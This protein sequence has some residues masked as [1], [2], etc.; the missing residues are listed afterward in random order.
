MCMSKWIKDV[1]PGKVLCGCV[2][3]LLF[4]T[5]LM[6]AGPDPE[7][8]VLYLPFEDAT[9]PIDGS[10]DPT[11]VVIHGSLNSADG[12]LGTKGLEFD[13]NNANRVEVA[14]A[15]KLDGMSALTIEAWV[16]TRGVA[17]YEGMSLASKRIAFGDGDVY[18]LFIY[19][20]QLVNGRVNA[21]NTNVGLSTTVIQDD[22]W[23]HIALVFDGQGNAGEK[24]KLYINGVLE[25]S[26]DHPDSG[27]N[28]GDAPIWIGELD[29]ARGFAWDGVL[30]EIG[31]WNIALSE[32]D[33]N[34]LMV[35][36]KAKMLRGE[37]AGTPIPSDGAD[38]VPITT[39]LAW[40]PGEY[41]VTH[42]VYFGTVF[43]D[44]N[45]GA[46]TL[47]SQGQTGTSYDPD[48]VLE[49]G[50]TY[51]WRVDEV[52]GAPDNTTFKGD[53]WSFTAEPMGYPIERI[54]A[55]S[56]GMSQAGAL[57]DNT[58][59][60]SGL[61][62]DDQHSVDSPDMW[63][64]TRTG[65]EPLYIAFEF[66]RVYKMHE[67]LVWN[68]N[69]QFELM[70][71]FGIQNATV[72]Y[73]ENGVDWTVLGDVELTQA[74]ARADYT[75]NTTVDFQGVPAQFVK[76]TVNSAFGILPV[77]QYGL[78]EVR[79]LFIPAQ[80]REPQPDDGAT[81]VAVD[82]TLGWR[83]GRDAVSH[84]VNFG[85]DPNAPALAGTVDAASFDPGA[86]DLGTAYYW[87]VDAIQD[88]ESW[89]GDLWSFSTQAHRVVDDFESYTDDI[90]AGEA[91][92][93]TWI[94]GYESLDNGSM[95]GHIEAPFA[96]RTIV[97]S[98]NQSMPL[99]YDNT[100]A[101][102]SEAE[103]A[104]AQ[105]WTTN[106]IKSLS[107]YFHGAAGNTGQLYVKTNGVK[108]LYDGD[109]ADIARATWQP[110]N[111]DL[112]A[113]GGNL[114]N[115]TSLIVGVEGAGATGV[116]YIDDIRLYPN[117]PELITPV[118]PDGANLVAS[119]AFEGNA[120]DG[121]G[122]GHNGAIVGDI[123]FENDPIRGQVVSLPGGEDQYISIEGVGVSGAA[124]RTIAC[125]AKADN[126]AIPDWTL[127]FGFTGDAA[128]EGG[129]GS[130]FNIGSLGGPGGVGAHCW[131]WEET[132]FSDDEALEWH[133]YA[134]SYDGTTIQYYGDGAPMDTDPA[135]SN[136]RDL[137]PSSDRVHVGSR[138]TQTSSFPGKVDDAVIY[139]VTLTDGEVAYLAGRTA[140]LHKAF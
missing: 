140:P 57:P 132:I 52:N 91:I 92:F 18:N 24:I 65:D 44:V 79:F 80:A 136:I 61:N 35:Q 110:W 122:N 32:E 114:S 106:G 29:A 137:S 7:G 17:G 62:A 22:T 33:I 9:N 84:E 81:D 60:G 45:D 14:D 128:G 120:A 16:L 6:A 34:Q 53:V 13:G 75:A 31:I 138:I 56:N 86:L 2:L 55:T 73:S 21:N 41:A 37:I 125:W 74:T 111:I 116:V 71:G 103:L 58:I 134:M 3:L 126:T 124:P 89:E 38:D 108:V 28:G 67:M 26:D 98:G 90:E 8:L 5:I 15:D 139:S 68:Y 23:Y 102:I 85:T 25:S 48:G 115:V 51:Y 30:D 117:A 96:E 77:P 59:N 97:N 129:N 107:L 130:H 46:D 47:V 119:Y 83:S 43:D 11:T 63:L 39:D 36:T 64:A 49:F 12:Q 76:L 113:V 4:N 93:L 10:A 1:R 72:E 112:S 27:V 94:D 121:S 123:T 70:L 20:G 118:E 66:D 95:V 88:A 105:N 19:T 50:Q 69:V 100:G 40:S 54:I 127:I 133:H 135:N 104:L 87:Q 131:G 101:S 42:D 99:F 109:V 82:A 78:S